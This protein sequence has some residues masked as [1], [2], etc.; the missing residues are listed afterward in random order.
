MRKSCWESLQQLVHIEEVGAIH[1]DC[2]FPGADSCDRV[3]SL[4]DAADSGA[5]VPVR[6]AAHVSKPQCGC[7]GWP[8]L[9]KG[10]HTLHQNGF[11]PSNESG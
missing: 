2:L 10:L 7:S 8:P 11:L 5:D 1:T 3:C 4:R 6:H 9:R